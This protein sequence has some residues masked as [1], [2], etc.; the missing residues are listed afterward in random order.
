GCPSTR[1]QSGHFGACLMMTPK[2]VAD[3]VRS[4]RATVDIPVTVKCRIGVDELD[5]YDDLLRFANIVIDAGSDRIS[6]H[7][8]KAWLKGLS[9]K[10]NRNVPPLRYADVYRLKQE[11]GDYPVEINGGIIDLDAAQT[12]MEHVDAVMIGRGVRDNPWILHDADA[13]FFG[14]PPA[15]STREQ[16]ARSMIPYI[17]A[18][19]AQGVP[20]KY[21]VR[22]LGPLFSGCRG[23]KAWRIAMA[24]AHH[25]HDPTSVIEEGLSRLAE[26]AD[27]P[28]PSRPLRT[29]QT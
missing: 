27:R 7:A 1:V 23:A 13:R 4:M 28:R 18:H 3:C 25:H 19:A 12:Q 9:P 24:S 11:L 10:Q 8:R 22:H 5:T 2:V 29:R 26:I 14:G 6:V 16:V 21:L 15:S 17:K 20:V